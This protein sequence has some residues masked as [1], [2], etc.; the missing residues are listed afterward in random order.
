[1]LF[2][3]RA[4]GEPFGKKDRR[5]LEDLARHIGAA[6]YAVR[7]TAELQRS[8]EELVRTR[9]EERR[10]LRRDLHDGLGP[11]LAAG[12]LQLQVALDLIR[13][14]PDA[15]ERI[16]SRLAF[17][18]K[19]VVEDIR[20]LVEALRPPALD[21]L[22]LVCAIQERASHFG[23]PRRDEAHSGTLQVKVEA[24]GDLQGLPAAVEVAA[25]R[26]VCEALNNASRHG[27]ASVCS[28]RLSLWGEALGV[29]VLDDG[30][31]LAADYRGGVGL[32]SMRER[33]AEL[34]GTCVIASAPSGGTVV[35]A[36][37][38]LPTP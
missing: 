38:P 15:A 37:L 26:I 2:G 7:V 3:E 21:Q 10:R 6:A 13:T 1:M 25:Y 24:D 17:E 32:A 8:R 5:L 4:R 9:E 31:G 33:A 34:G 35:R 28:V 23:R 27:G 30:R 12:I 16:L 14:D 20:R 29:E 18:A 36:R 19:R 11:T 22:G